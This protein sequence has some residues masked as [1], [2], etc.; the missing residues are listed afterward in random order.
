MPYDLSRYRSKQVIFQP[1][2]V[3]GYHY[4]ITFFSFCVRKYHT[5]RVPVLDHNLR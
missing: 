2:L 4:Q 3:R 5:S 1:G